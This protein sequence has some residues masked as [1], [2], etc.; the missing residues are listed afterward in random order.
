MPYKIRCIGAPMD[1][2]QDLRGVDVG[3]SALRYAGLMQRLQQLGHQVED[4]GNVE[5]AVRTVLDPP[6]HGTMFVEA[7]RAV[8]Q[9]LYT[10]VRQAV[11]DGCVPLVMGGDHSIAIGAIGGATH[12]EPAGVLWIDAHADFN[13]PD[14]SPSGNIHGMPLAVLTGR[15]LQELVNIGR[16]GAKLAPEDVVLI[17]LR[18]IDPAERLRLVESGMNIFTMR[19][20]DEQ[21]IAA[22]TRMALK[23][24]GHHRRIHVSFDVDSIDPMF[25]PG[26]GTPVSGGLSIREAHL[27]MEIIAEDGRISSVDVVEINPILDNKNVTAVLA[28][29]LLASLLGKTI[30]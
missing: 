25:A 15:G 27:L 22:V 4:I 11:A 23:R 30:V 21:G 9:L 19:E 2:G 29:E 1:L 28:A 6:M 26:V 18:Q 20:I 17:A 5:V 7:I 14:T 12:E 24:L 13:T 16:P 10:A 8:C 3:P